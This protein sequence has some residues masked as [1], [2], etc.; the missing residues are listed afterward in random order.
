[1]EA[2]IPLFIFMGVGMVALVLILIGI[3]A[4]GRSRQA[5]GPTTDLPAPAPVESKAGETVQSALAES[6][7][8]HLQA[9]GSVAMEIDGQRFSRLVDIG[10][11]RLYQRALAAVS[12]LQKFAGIISD[13]KP[14]PTDLEGELRAGYAKE[15]RAFVVEFRG[16][17]FRKLAE[18]KDGET[19]RGVLGMIGKLDT[20]AQGLA[21]PPFA[22]PARPVAV[23]SSAE[24]EFLRQL[25]APAAEQKPL[26]M[27]SLVESLRSTPGRAEPMPVGIAGQ[28]ERILQQ[29][30]VDN[31]LLIGRAIHVITMKDG[32]L[33]VQM[34]GKTLKWP[35]EVDP[36]VREAVQSAIRAWEKS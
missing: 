1:V 7:R 14:A 30:L 4:R 19:G 2:A 15:D 16:Q 25:A 27:P 12:A 31:S 20:F 18:I 22:Q 32:S 11:E 28:I 34:E 17:R 3:F 10:E 13:L 8:L 21:V 29:Q 35:D 6:I 24:E 33:G 5:P 9:D 26:R 36:I 23:K